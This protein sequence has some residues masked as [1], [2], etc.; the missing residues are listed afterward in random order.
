M[1]DLVVADPLSRVFMQDFGQ[2]LGIGDSKLSRDLS[3]VGNV[4]AANIRVSLQLRWRK[5]WI[6]L[7]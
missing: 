2:R 5:N 4:V 3:Y 6:R 7:P 1:R